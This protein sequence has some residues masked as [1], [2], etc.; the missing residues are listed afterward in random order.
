[1]S[2]LTYDAEALFNIRVIKCF[3]ANPDNAW[4]N[5]Y[6]VQAHIAGSEDELLACATKIVD[7][8]R[9]LHHSAVSFLRLLI[10]TWAPDSVPY[11][12][13]AFISSTL[14]GVGE[15]APAGQPVSVNDC[16]SVAR[17][18]ASGRL[19]HL[20]YRG[21]LLDG[22]FSAPA[23]KN[24]LTNKVAMQS[25]IDASLVGSDFEEHLGAAGLASIGLVMVGKTTAA[26]RNV[27]GLVTV[28]VASVPS[29]HAWY[30]RSSAVTP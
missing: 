22:D 12:P 26:V 1:M 4:V 10:S 17:V 7:F 20:F 14:T 13:S 19:G 24:V 16:L 5:N 18:C 2:V 30:N 28:G 23:G 8:E 27:L 21:V 29:D 25:F 6:E 15:R 3:T 11:D 9:L